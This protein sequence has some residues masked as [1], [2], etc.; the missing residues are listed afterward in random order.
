MKNVGGQYLEV[1]TKNLITSFIC[2]FEKVLNFPLISSYDV[3]IKRLVL[4][5][6]HV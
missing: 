6:V 1:F 3:N 2:V 5:S 4:P